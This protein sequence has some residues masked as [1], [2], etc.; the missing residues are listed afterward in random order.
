METMT[1]VFVTVFGLIWGSF[2]NVVIH[3]LPAGQSLLRPGSRCPRCLKPIRAYD[4]VPLLSFLV[5]GGRCR[6][7]RTK[8]PLTYPL[9][10]VLTAACFLTLHGAFGLSHFFFASCL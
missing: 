1:A 4:N 5:L 3:R 2:L 9:V 8:I 10:E 6:Y 7:C